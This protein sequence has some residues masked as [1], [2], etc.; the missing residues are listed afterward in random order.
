LPELFRKISIFKM[1][2]SHVPNLWEKLGKPRYVCAPMVEQSD[3]PFRLLLRKH[4]VPL[5]YT[6]MI[7]SREFLRKPQKRSNMFQTCPEDR[8]LIAQFCANDPDILLQ[9]TKIVEN[10]VDAVDLNFGC[11]QS[12]ARRGNYGAFLL[13]QVDL[14]CSLISILHKNLKVPVTCKIRILPDEEDTMKMVHR[15]ADAGI[16][17]LTVHGRTKEEN[18]QLVRHCNW[19]IIKRIKDELNIPVF[20]NGGAETIED[21]DEC[22]KMT[23]VDAYMAAESLLSD[24]LMF[25]PGHGISCMQL[26]NMYMDEVAYCHQQFKHITTPKTIRPHLFKI[27]FQDLQ[28]VPE[29]RQN[30]GRARAEEFRVV[31]NTLQQKLKEMNEHD[32]KMMQGYTWPWYRRHNKTLESIANKKRKMQ[33]LQNEYRKRR[34]IVNGEGEASKKPE[35]DQIS[36]NEEGKENTA[37]PAESKP[38]GSKTHV[39]LMQDF[40]ATVLEQIDKDVEEENRNKPAVPVG[41]RK[42]KKKKNRKKKQVQ[43]EKGKENEGKSIT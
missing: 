22:M 29:L 30:L 5:C 37:E 33:F 18:K 34:K 4:G 20:A 12:I 36:K 42:K 43:T 25:D 19:K 1:A 35:K 31:I 32:Y 13:N 3:L 21:A 27:L 41:G 10:D 16:S 2:S 38:D 14:M 24:P 8:P 9:A 6:P 40:N 17:I 28:I 23:G 26:A 15:L 11:P 7:H 39:F